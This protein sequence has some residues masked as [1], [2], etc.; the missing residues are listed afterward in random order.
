MENRLLIVLQIL[1]ALSPAMCADINPLSDDREIE[2]VSDESLSTSL[3]SIHEN[4]L[5]TFKIITGEP[6]V[7]AQTL[8][9][10]CNPIIIRI[11][12]ADVII[13]RRNITLK[14]DFRNKLDDMRYWRATLHFIDGQPI[15]K[16]SNVRKK[17]D[18]G[19]QLFARITK[20]TLRDPGEEVLF[21]MKLGNAGA[22][23]NFKR[24]HII[25]DCQ[26]MTLDDEEVSIISKYRWILNKSH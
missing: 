4:R 19:R 22:K 26:M 7:P 23:V 24:H 8:R 11:S 3:I 17:L 15:T 2:D 13:N 14:F 1:A 6:I 9:L 12:I 10:A 5:E 25:K 18:N 21:Q 20:V 16:T